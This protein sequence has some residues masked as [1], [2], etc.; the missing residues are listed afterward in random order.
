MIY[1]MATDIGLHQVR[2]EDKGGGCNPEPG[3][4]VL[5]GAGSHNGFRAK[6]NATRSL[7]RGASAARSPVTAAEVARIVRPA[8]SGNASRSWPARSPGARASSIAAALLVPGGLWLS[9]QREASFGQTA[10]KSTWLPESSW[11]SPSRAA[12]AGLTIL[13]KCNRTEG[14]CR[15]Q[16]ESDESP[17]PGAWARPPGVVPRFLSAKLGQFSPAG[18]V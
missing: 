7:L 13:P 2:E 6:D 12:P 9:L 18:P 5:A 11:R 15:A 14:L 4:F 3:S 17:K 10:R 1:P 8:G 16:E